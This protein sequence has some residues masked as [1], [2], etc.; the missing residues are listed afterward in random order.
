VKKRLPAFGLLLVIMVLG[1]GLVLVERYAPPRY[2]PRAPLSLDDPI[3][4]ATRM[5]LRRLRNKPEAC[6]DVLSASGAAFT[7]VPDRTMGRGCGFKNVVALKGVRVGYTPGPPKLTCPMA[8][9]VILWQR[10]I[11]APAAERH[12]GTQP[13]TIRHYGS[14]A[15]R[16]VGGAEQGRR[17]QH[18]TANA[19]DIA[20]ITMVN[21]ER[22]TLLEDWDGKAE[23]AKFWRAV[24]DGAC[25]VFSVVLSPDHDR[26]HANHLH[27]DLGRARTCR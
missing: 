2:D 7:P 3:T 11:V 8:V 26:A 23:R 1:T 9:A 12:L 16:N 15:C 24:R 20:A 10:K 22:L 18:A 25:K 4:F 13:E 17:S 27:L 5:K 19:L 6:L 21:G 14:Y